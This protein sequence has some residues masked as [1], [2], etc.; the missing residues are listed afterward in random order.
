[1]PEDEINTLND[2]MIA[3]EILDAKLKLHFRHGL[4]ALEAYMDNLKQIDMSCGTEEELWAE[5]DTAVKLRPH[6]KAPKR[7]PRTVLLGPPGSQNKEF[8]ER[9]ADQL[10]AVVIDADVLQKEAMVESETIDFLSEA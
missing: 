7:A 10:G 6:S 8:A 4:A 5:I 1:M 2:G 3:Q 9:L